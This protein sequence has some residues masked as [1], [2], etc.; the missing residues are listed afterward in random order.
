MVFSQKLYFNIFSGASAP[1]SVPKIFKWQDKAS[2]TEVIG[3]WNPGGY[4]TFDAAGNVMDHIVSIPSYPEA[5]AFFFR[6]DN[7]GMKQINSTNIFS[8]GPPDAKEVTNTFATLQ[9]LFP[10]ANIVASKFDD[11]VDGVVKSKVALPLYTA[12]IGDTW[13]YGCSSDPLKLAQF[14]AMSRLRKECLQNSKCNPN[15]KNFKDFNRFLLKLGEHT[16]GTDVKIHLHDFKNWSNAQFTAA[17][18]QSNY[19]NLVG[20]W[21]EQRSFVDMALAALGPNELAL[22]IHEE[23]KELVPSIPSTH[24]FVPADPAKRYTSGNLIVGF[25]TETG[26]INY[27][28]DTRKK[29]NYASA[30]NTLGQILYQTY[31]ADDYA[32]FLAN[33]MYCNISNECRWGGLDFGKPNVTLG[34]PVHATYTPKLKALYQ[35]SNAG[36]DVFLAELT[37]DESAHQ[38]AG[39]PERC[40]VEYAIHTNVHTSEM[41]IRVMCFNKTPTRLPESLSVTF[42][43]LVNNPQNWFMDKLGSLVSP[44]DVLRNGSQHQHGIQTGLHYIVAGDT[45]LSIHSLDAGVV[46]PGAPT[47]FPT[48]LQQQPDMSL[49]FHFNL[50]NNIWGT[51]YIMWYPFNEQD[52]NIAYRFKVVI[53]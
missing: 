32:K 25:D 16:W 17:K 53:A 10:N 34:N 37:M 35:K 11:F 52:E 13:L 2:Q 41:H 47:P 43:P 5:I 50:V 36:K 24:D 29:Q 42:N 14:R 49:G 3:M 18:T 4:G 8:I 44:M 27:L 28:Y 33:Y 51:N 48:P 39:A 12:E 38:L 23:L 19:V 20:S 45:Q 21:I 9:S 30:S 26:A 22:A 15:D 6:S 40:F 46:M 7:A 1:P 31:D